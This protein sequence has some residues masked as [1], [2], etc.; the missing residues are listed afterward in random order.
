M[1][2]KSLNEIAVSNYSPEAYLAQLRARRLEAYAQ[3][4]Q[5]SPGPSTDRADNI[6]RLQMSLLAALQNSRI[7]QDSLDLREQ[8]MLM[9]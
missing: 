2:R 7:K 1:A 4:M 5:N 3:A 6:R 8:K 9:G